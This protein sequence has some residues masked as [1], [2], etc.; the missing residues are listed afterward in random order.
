MQ[1]ML[2][3]SQASSR[4]TARLLVV[5]DDA[6][7]RGLL[8]RIFENEFLIV[9]AA[10]G[11]E[12]LN[13]LEREEFDIVLLD[14]MMPGMDGFEVLYRIRQ[15]PAFNDLPVI[16]ISAKSDNSD[17]V[18]GL[19]MGAHDYIA[20]PIH[21]D[22]VR[23]RVK[24]QLTLKRLSDEHKRT[25]DELRIAQQMQDNFYRIVSHDLKG[26]LT[27]LRMAHFLL[28]DMVGGDEQFSTILNNVE[29]SLNEM[30]DMIR[31]FL[32]V[33]MLQP[34]RVQVELD[35]LGVEE[36]LQN[37][38]QQY[39]LAA[40][41]KHIHI[42]LEPSDLCVL[43]DNRLIHQMMG[44]LLSNA[45]K[46]S[47]PDTTVTLWAEAEGDWLRLYV[48]DQGPGIPAGESEKLFEM[49]SRLSTRPTGSESST[50]LGL[51]IVKQ[52]TEAQNGHVG[53]ESPPD[54]GAI[55]WIEMPMCARG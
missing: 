41:N 6:V 2:R 34:G 3:Q 43:A 7:N 17:V 26:P 44:N 54:G 14:L 16:I 51:W 38:V 46:F 15:N 50:G 24:T 8:Q 30:H 27:N 29:L 31:V 11:I 33:M 47:Y 23:A 12:A 55:F 45:L 37:V 21:I 32:D 53:F 13:L 52:L 4:T 35:C 49:F 36:I 10:N 40:E 39:S 19:E 25:I 22:I 9:C 20:K 42:H 1:A 48:A 28:Q 18:H 5:D